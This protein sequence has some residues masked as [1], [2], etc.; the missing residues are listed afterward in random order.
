MR[1]GCRP[2][3]LLLAPEE[4]PGY[5]PIDGLEIPDTGGPV[6][7]YPLTDIVTGSEFCNVIPETAPWA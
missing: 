1:L 6:T 5:R 7:A 3:K 2:A 4:L